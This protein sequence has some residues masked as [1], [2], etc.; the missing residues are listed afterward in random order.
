MDDRAR[1]RHGVEARRDLAVLEHGDAIG[2]PG[3]LA[4]AMGDV[5]DR[6]AVR[7]QRIDGLE[8]LPALRLVERCGRLV[9]HQN[10][11]VE[12]DCLGDLDHLLGGH[13]EF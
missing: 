10:P 6:R 9:H 3:H 12:R 11:G 4:H 5:D 7:A 2:E 8:Q 1:V 13:V